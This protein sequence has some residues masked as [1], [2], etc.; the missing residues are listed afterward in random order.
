MSYGDKVKDESGLITSFCTGQQSDRQSLS[1]P[2]W[3]KSRVPYNPNHLEDSVKW[4]EVW[5]TG[6]H[7]IGIADSTSLN[8][9]AVSSNNDTNFSD[10]DKIVVKNWEHTAFQNWKI[11][12]YNSNVPY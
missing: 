2:A 10:G 4:T 1:A 5:S 8:L 11:V 3:R 12:P 9:T 6:F 7:F